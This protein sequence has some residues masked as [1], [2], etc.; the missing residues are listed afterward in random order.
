MTTYLP[1]TQISRI[2]FYANVMTPSKETNPQTHVSQHLEF[3]VLIPEKQTTAKSTTQTV[4][5]DAT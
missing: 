1:S 4:S 5:S 2:M 3:A